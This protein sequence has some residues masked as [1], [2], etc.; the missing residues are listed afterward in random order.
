MTIVMVQYIHYNCTVGFNL[1]VFSSIAQP[2]T[3]L[4]FLH[5]GESTFNALISAV[6][7]FISESLI[8]KSI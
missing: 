4:Y 2:V 5:A 3:F 6:N 1:L 8:T 7:L